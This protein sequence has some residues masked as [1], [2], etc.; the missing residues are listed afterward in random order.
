MSVLLLDLAKVKGTSPG[1]PPSAP[2]CLLPDP[3]PSRCPEPRS[4]V[5]TGRWKHLPHPLLNT[6]QQNCLHAASQ[7]ASSHFPDRQTELQSVTQLRPKVTTGK[8]ISLMPQKQQVQ[9]TPLPKS[10]RWLL[11]NST[12]LRLQ[13]TACASPKPP[14]LL[15]YSR[16]WISFRKASKENT[17]PSE[18]PVSFSLPWE[19]LA[20]DYHH[21]CSRQA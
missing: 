3:P 19:V 18:N 9:G 11:N 4:A 8:V 6:P 7:T 20:T 16:F 14:D 5:P 13:S 1:G 21:R 12:D 10:A 15:P 2:Y 17:T